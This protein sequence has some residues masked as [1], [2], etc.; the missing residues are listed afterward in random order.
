MAASCDI[1]FRLY[2]L[3]RRSIPAAISCACSTRMRQPRKP[4]ARRSAHSASRLASV[5]VFESAKPIALS[6]SRSA[7]RQYAEPYTI[8]PSVGPRPASSIPI[9][10]S[11]WGAG[12]RAWMRGTEAGAGWGGRRTWEERSSS[13]Q[14]SS[15]M[16][17]VALRPAE[18]A[19]THLG[20]VRSG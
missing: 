10:T 13:T 5:R 7:T 17:R 9:I 16:Q 2:G 8:G 20:V 1:A 11:S 18:S 12:E 19:A 4:E 15:G 6:L 3:G 14:P